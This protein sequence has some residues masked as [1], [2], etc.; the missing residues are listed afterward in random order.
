MKIHIFSLFHASELT[1]VVPSGQGNCKEIDDMPYH[2][3]FYY[4]RR[5]MHS[6]PQLRCKI[7]EDFVFLSNGLMCSIIK[8]IIRQIIIHKHVLYA[9]VN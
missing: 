2:R 3:L 8:F 6:G 7:N 9:I 1:A 4:G 5:T